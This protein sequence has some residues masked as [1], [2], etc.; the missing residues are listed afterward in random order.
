MHLDIDRRTLAQLSA[1]L[2]KS[3]S[4]GRIKIESKI[5]MKRRGTT[6]PD[7]AEAI[8]LALYE[9]PNSGIVPIVAPIMLEQTS[10]WKF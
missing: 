1:P 10:P 7:R 9:P 5:E 3:D 2:Y 6:S 8:L 4:S